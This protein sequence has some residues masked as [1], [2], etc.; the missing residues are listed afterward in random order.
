MKFSLFSS[1]LNQF[2]AEKQTFFFLFWL[3]NKEFSLFS[4]SPLVLSWWNKWLPNWN[5]LNQETIWHSKRRTAHFESSRNA[6]RIIETEFPSKRC[7]SNETIVK[8]RR[9][10]WKMRTSFMDSVGTSRCNGRLYKEELRRCSWLR[11]RRLLSLWVD[12][13][14]K[15]EENEP[16]LTENS[17]KIGWKWLK[18]LRT[19]LKSLKSIRLARLRRFRRRWC[20][21]AAFRKKKLVKNDLF[22]TIFAE[23]CVWKLAYLRRDSVAGIFSKKY[24]NFCNKIDKVGAS[25]PKLQV[26]DQSHS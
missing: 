13:C 3:K 15:L 21:F 7:E 25:R 11:T 17:S 18:S 1:I 24:H 26:A 16:N 4:V 23:V 2:S 9:I 6:N 22:S 19:V 5:L 10:V 12:G 20:S 14:W 8:S